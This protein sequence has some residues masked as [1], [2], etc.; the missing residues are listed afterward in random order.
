MPDGQAGDTAIQEDC[1]LFF[2]C[3][4]SGVSMAHS[5][6]LRKEGLEYVKVDTEFA[7]NSLGMTPH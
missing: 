1:K 2:Q 6:K 7:M 4:I 5:A 3:D